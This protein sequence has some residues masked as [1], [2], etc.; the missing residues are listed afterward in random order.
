MIP[1]RDAAGEEETPAGAEAPAGGTS[2]RYTLFD[3][4]GQVL[5]GHATAEPLHANDVVT[6][7]GRQWRIVAVVGAM[8]TVMHADWGDVR[9]GG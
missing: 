3:C 5:G 6:V 8:A 2:F 7:T 1:V 4:D 9:P